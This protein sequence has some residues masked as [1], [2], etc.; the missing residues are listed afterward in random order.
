[1]IVVPGLAFDR[2][3]RRLGRGGAYYDRF[4]AGLNAAGQKYTAIG[5][6]MAAQIVP[7]VPTEKWDKKMDGICS[8]ITKLIKST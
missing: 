3:G 5:L 8:A 7:E 1:M 2:S 6:C 4:L